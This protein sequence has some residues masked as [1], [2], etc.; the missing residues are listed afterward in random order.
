MNVLLHR[1]LHSAVNVS[2]QIGGFWAIEENQYVLQATSGSG[3]S[4]C[5]SRQIWQ[6]VIPP[7]VCTTN[8]HSRCPPGGEV[9]R[10]Q[11]KTQR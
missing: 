10:Q 5:I 3:D 6:T 8:G 7:T 11:A 9:N 2:L 4:V 1:T